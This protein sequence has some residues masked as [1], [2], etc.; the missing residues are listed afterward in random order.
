MLSVKFKIYGGVYAE[1]EWL[2]WQPVGFLNSR[3]ISCTGMRI[4]TLQINAVFYDGQNRI[5]RFGNFFEC[6]PS[7]VGK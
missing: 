2:S 6:W 4:R 7:V 1:E 5:K 3:F